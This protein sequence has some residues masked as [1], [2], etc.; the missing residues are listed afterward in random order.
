M[1]VDFS[2]IE[3]RFTPTDDG[4]CTISQKGMIATQSSQASE[5]GAQILRA[6]GNAVDAATAAALVLAVTEPQACGLGGQTMMLIHREGSVIAVDGSSRAPSLAHVSAVYKQDRTIGYRATTIPST[7]ATLW[8]THDRY[9]RLPWPQVVEPAGA[10]AKHGFKT[11]PF[12]IGCSS[13]N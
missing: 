10:L 6:G 3:S 4:K 2:A 11:T 13:R 12:K 1:A 9:G 5:A 8:Y 7:P